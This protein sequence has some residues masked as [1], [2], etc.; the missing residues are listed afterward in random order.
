MRVRFALILSQ[1]LIF[2]FEIEGPVNAGWGLPRKAVIPDLH[3]SRISKALCKQA[4][5]L[6]RSA[7]VHL[8]GASF[9]KKKLSSPCFKSMGSLPCPWD[10]STIPK[11]W[12]YSY[13]FH[14]QAEILF[15]L[16]Y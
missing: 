6:H 4:F 9:Q 3:F 12:H 7:E 1:V 13:V 11:Q 8:E 5:I 16:N 14:R 15:Q 10:L 2:G